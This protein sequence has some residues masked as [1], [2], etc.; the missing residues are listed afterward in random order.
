MRGRARGRSSGP[1]FRSLRLRMGVSHGLVLALILV[2]MGGTGYLL[3]ARSLNRSATASVVEAAREATERVSSSRSPV[4]IRP[5]DDVPSATTI[6]VAAFLNDGRVVSDPG[7]RPSWLRPQREP[8]TTLSVLGERVRIATVPLRQDGRVIGQV[9]AARSL[10]PEDRLLDRVRLLLLL[11]GLMAVLLGMLAGWVLAG[12]AAKPVRRAYEAQASFAS[13]ASHEFRTPLAFVRSGVE[14]LAEHDQELGDEVLREVTY[15]AGLTDRLLTLARSDSKGLSLET[16]P[17]DLGPVCERAVDR[18]H[19]VLSLRAD[20]VRSKG[21]VA[22][23]DPVAFEAALDAVLENAARHGGGLVTVTLSGDGDRVEVWVADHGPGM[24]EEHRRMAFERFFRADP[25][26]SREQGGAGLGL[27]V[28]R[29]LME[30]QR[31]TLSLNETP[32]GGL[33][34]VLGLV[35]ASD[36][37]AAAH[38]AGPARVESA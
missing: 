17:L 4:N 19:R 10:A 30:A 6:R 18:A 5:D 22:M 14:V 31:G 7:R 2:L 28:A 32:G 37:P 13:D 23:G 12:R 3:L 16:R 34:A 33:T 26:R 15:L 9:V 36:R 38:N 27:S 25:A 24:T 29:A 21:C 20:V 35:A 1:L 8:T 11:G